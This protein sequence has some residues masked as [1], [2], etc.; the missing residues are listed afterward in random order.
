[1]KV[2]Y[3]ISQGVHGFATVEVGVADVLALAIAQDPRRLAALITDMMWKEHLTLRTK[4]TDGQKEYL[5]E[6][7]E[8]ITHV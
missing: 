5:R 7:V 4:L 6:V 8:V 3:E 2:D 1:M